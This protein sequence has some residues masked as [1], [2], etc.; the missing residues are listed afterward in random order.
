M[1]NKVNQLSFFLFL[2]SISPSDVSMK[3]KH[4]VYI[5]QETFEIFCFRVKDINGVV[6]GLAVSL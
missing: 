5:K 4:L 6:E 3:L 1:Y 2:M